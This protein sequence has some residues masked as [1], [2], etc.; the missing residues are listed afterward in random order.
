MHKFQNF[1]AATLL[2][3]DKGQIKINHAP[4]PKQKKTYIDALHSPSRKVQGI[5]HKEG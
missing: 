5:I 4:M 3:I 2:D 1:V